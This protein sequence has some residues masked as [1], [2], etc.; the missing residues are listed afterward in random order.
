MQD[1]LL[2]FGFVKREWVSLEERSGSDIREQGIGLFRFCYEKATVLLR[3]MPKRL[4]N[5]RSKLKKL[6]KNS[7]NCCSNIFK[8][9]CLN[10]IATAL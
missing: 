5:S 3:N 8:T 9:A 10:L 6:L 1:K 4:L 7:V 2:Y